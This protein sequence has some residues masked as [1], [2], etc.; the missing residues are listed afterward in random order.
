VDHLF[1]PCRT[2]PS[3]SKRSLKPLKS[4]K[5]RSR[6]KAGRKDKKIDDNDDDKRKT[7]RGRES[8]K[9]TN[10]V[11]DGDHKKQIVQMH[12]I[13]LSNNTRLR[14]VKGKIEG[15]DTYR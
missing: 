14:I 1:G 10:L 9:K 5:E 6:K 7:E 4:E 8:F 11:T 12:S 13:G 15:C 2:G 3:T